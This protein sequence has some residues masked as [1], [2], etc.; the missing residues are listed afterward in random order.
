MK[1]ESN[2]T[3]QRE[4]THEALINVNQTQS[5]IQFQNSFTNS[6]LHL[7]IIGQICYRAVRKVKYFH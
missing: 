4:T 1:S 5:Y 6:V 7:P 3:H 2:I